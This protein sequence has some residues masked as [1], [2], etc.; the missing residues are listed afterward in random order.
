MA[1]AKPAPGQWELIALQ[2]AAVGDDCPYE[3][4]GPSDSLASCEAACQADSACNVI[5]WSA[6][7]PDC[8]FR[9]CSDPAHPQLTPYSD[10]SVYAYPTPKSSAMVTTWHTDTAVMMV[11]CNSDAVC[12]GITSTGLLLANATALVPTPGV[13]TWVKNS[14]AG[15]PAATEPAAA[16]SPR[17]TA[18]TYGVPPLRSHSTRGV[19]HATTADVLVTPAAYTGG[20]P[21]P[22]VVRV[23]A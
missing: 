13:S 23:A 15:A 18:A 1:P 14:A 20:V 19:P 8:V 4:H 9:V 12:Q 11:L 21:P 10:Y 16:T 6:S 17:S 3:A 7:I 5:N 22:R 2:E